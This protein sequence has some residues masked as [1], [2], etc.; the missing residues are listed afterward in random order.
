MTRWTPTDRAPRPRGR[1]SLHL[2]RPPPAALA[3]SRADSNTSSSQMPQWV[4]LSGRG[5]LILHNHD[6][7]ITPKSI[8]G[9]L[10]SNTQ[11]NLEFFQ[12]DQVLMAWHIYSIFFVCICV[13]ARLFEN[14]FQT[15]WYFIPKYFSS[16][17]P[18]SK[19]ILHIITM[20]FLHLW[21][22][23]L[24]QSYY[25]QHI[26]TFPQLSFKGLL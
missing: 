25:I 11:L 17:S 2:P 22:L 15:S 8:Y 13:I 4:T 6:T 9:S 3:R 20:Q 14:K 7:V 12:V 21:Q 19:N 26:F 5:A 24:I 18:K 23:I 16:C 10:I 1:S